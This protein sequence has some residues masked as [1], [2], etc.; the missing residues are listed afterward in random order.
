MKFLSSLACAVVLALIATSAAIA[1]APNNTYVISD[2]H[3]GIGAPPN[4]GFKAPAGLPCDL[5]GVVLPPLNDPKWLETEDFRWPVA[6]CG[7]LTQIANQPAG[8][9]LVIAGDFLELWQ[10]PQKQCILAANPECGCTVEEMEEITARVIAAHAQ[11]FAMLD[12][13]LQGNTKNTLVVVP[14]NH[15]AALMHDRIWALVRNA[16]PSAGTRLLRADSGT[17]ISADMQLVVEHGHQQHVPDVN[18]FPDWDKRKVTQQCGEGAKERFYAPWGE[19]FV[20]NLYTAIEYSLFP[21]IDN[22]VPDSAGLGVY[23]AETKLRGI[24]AREAARFIYFNVFETSFRQ[25]EQ[26]LAV[27]DRPNGQLSDIE[28]EACVQCIGDVELVLRDARRNEQLAKLLGEQA[29]AGTPEFAAAMA[30][31]RNKMPGQRL[32]KAHQ[33][34]LCEREGAADVGMKGKGI[35]LDAN[36]AACPGILSTAAAKLFD[37][38]GAQMLQERIESLRTPTDDGITTYV[39][40]HTHEAKRR[41]DVRL[42]SRTVGAFNTGAFHRQIDQAHFKSHPNRTPGESDPD[43]LKRLTHGDLAACYSVVAV[44][45]KKRNSGKYERVADLKHWYQDETSAQ[46]QFIDACDARCS[47]KPANCP[48]AGS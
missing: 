43:F 35:P 37:Q 30:E 1:Q 9:E 47:A 38:D 41:M 48:G 21:L 25:K 13:Y 27:N 45:Y 39:F 7:F 5:P 16:M 15:D 34:L 26:V 17:W 24:T 11:E 12:R 20:S 18:A 44:T 6:L 40:G 19:N 31:E 33:R 32:P 22:L 28:V 3:F 8:A 14:G 10:H 4:P 46:G 29:L 2:L 36:G 42:I 23:F